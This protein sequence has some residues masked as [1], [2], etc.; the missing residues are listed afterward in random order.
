MA[1]SNKE[2]CHCHEGLVEKRLIEE[3]QWR[4]IA[5]L[6]KP[7]E[8]WI[9]MRVVNPRVA[10]DIFDSAPIQALD[11]FTG[12]LFSQ[13][14]NPADRW[15]ELGVA[16]KDLQAWGPVKEYLYNFSQ[17]CYASFSPAVSSFYAMVPAS[18]GDLGAFGLGSGY[19]DLAQGASRFTDISIPLSQTWIETDGMGNLTRFHRD[20]REKGSNL[21]RMFGAQAAELDEKREYRICHAVFENPDFKQGA[22]GPR[23]M[24]WSSVYC[25][26]ESEGQNGDWRVEKGYYEMPYW[27]VPWNLRPGRYPMGPGHISRADVSML[28]AM[29]RAHIVAAQFETEPPLLA[30]DES[31]ISAADIEPRKLLYGA[32]NDQGKQLLQRLQSGS[33]LKLSLAQS[34]QRRAAIR[35]AFLFSVM[36]VVNRPQMTAQ[37]F[38]GWKE[39][40]LRLMAPNL[41]RIHTYGLAPLI[42]RRA[43]LLQR[44]GMVPP[45][46]PELLGKSIDV[47]FTSPLAKAQKAGQARA[48]LQFVGTLEQW[49]QAGNPNALDKV[50]F[51]AAADA[52]AD[53]LALDPSIVRPTDQAQQL[54][55][56][57]AQQ[58]AQAA[59]LEQA[60]H[61]ASIYA[62][63]AHANQAQTR[64]AGRTQGGPQQ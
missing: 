9:G 62:D 64:A 63:V 12:G 28:N 30:H 6:I 54:R 46:P 21:K 59:Q 8:R 43:R 20:W 24:A 18:W 26:L 55:Q 14:T 22:L 40:S 57:R 5:A 25:L 1:Y 53:G 47:G 16:D 32:L 35:E 27:S 41:G 49:A 17:L 15:F 13:S 45:P 52:Y 51:D 7:E 11:T 44:A 3:P 33:D 31:V 60:A 48:I 42:A 29:E 50:D 39:E 2:I 10:D 36:Q 19:S 23:G 56:A 4:E 37:E 38:L 61:A 34:E 58:Q